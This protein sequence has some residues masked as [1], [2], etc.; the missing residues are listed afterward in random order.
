MTTI[1]SPATRSLD[2]RGVIAGGGEPLEEILAAAEQVPLGGALDLV[3]PFEPLPLYAVMRRRGFAHQ[4]EARASGE[5]AVRFRQTGITPDR[6]LADVATQFPGTAAVLA[7]HGFDLCCG[8][9]KPIEL[10]ARAH[11]VDLDLLLAEL[12]ALAVPAQG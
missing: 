1:E 2:V 9:A 6:V 7:A 11:G 4:V 10:V 3:A 12:Q 8:G 5:W